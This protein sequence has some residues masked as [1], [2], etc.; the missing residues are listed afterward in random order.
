MKHIKDIIIQLFTGANVATIL[1]LWMSCGVTYLH[2]ESVPKLMLLTYA[3]PAFLLVNVAFVLFWL[4]FKI[5]RTWIPVVGI[6][7][8]WS[9]VRDY[10]PLN[11]PAQPSAKALKVLTYN[12]HGFGGS[13]AI[14]SLGQNAVCAYLKACDAD[15]ICLQESYGSKPSGFKQEME[16]LGYECIDMQNNMLFSRLPVLSADTLTRWPYPNIGI[17]AWLQ[18]E[19]DSILLFNVHFESNHL[20]PEMKQAYRNSIKSMEQDSLRRGLIPVAQLLAAAAPIRAAQADTLATLIDQYAAA[21][22]ILVCGDFND[23]PISYSHRV[24]TRSLH[25]AFRQSGQ[26]LGFSFH[27][28]G[29]PVRIDHILYSPSYFSSADTKVL[30][31]VPWSDHYPVMTTLSISK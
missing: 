5:K 4:V 15:I 6:A 9:F 13:T 30:T 31:D 3:F 11:F 29:F 28:H 16:Q 18:H 2:P 8:C 1:L 14:D 19:G 20:S 17:Q 27:E 22:P 24:L 7:A 25:S 10:Y 21:C 12:T 23:T 26:G